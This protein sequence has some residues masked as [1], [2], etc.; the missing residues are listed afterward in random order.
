[1][2]KGKA[3]K[4]LGKPTPLEYGFLFG[5]PALFLLIAWALASSFIGPPPREATVKQIR[6]GAVKVGMSEADVLA[7]VGKP[8]GIIPKDD[9]GF[10]Y[11]YQSSAWDP[12]RKSPL[13]E[14]AY[15]E[16]SDSGSVSGISFDSRVPDP[17]PGD[18]SSAKP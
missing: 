10:T 8:K 14:D 11:R 6:Q 18:K 7:K 5:G 9:G 3:G 12:D 17:V 1:M 4:R 16:F 15:V 13:E 2:D